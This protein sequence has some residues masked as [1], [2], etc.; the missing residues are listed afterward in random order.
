MTATDQMRAMLDAMMGTQRN[1]KKSEPEQVDEM[2]IYERME[3]L[4]IKRIK[5]DE[6]SGRVFVR[7]R[8]ISVSE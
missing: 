8:F 1:G 7:V 4:C 3:E 6:E 5:S 2:L